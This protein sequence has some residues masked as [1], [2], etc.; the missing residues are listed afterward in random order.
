MMTRAE[1]TEVVLAAKHAKG[2]TFEAIARAVGR[3]QVWVM[4][5][6]GAML[7]TVGLLMI[8]GVW[9]DWIASMQGWIRGFEPAV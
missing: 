2:L 6:G 8:T 4:R 9:A 5:A 7:V 1:A 3:H